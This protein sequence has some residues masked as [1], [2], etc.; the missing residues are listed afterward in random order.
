MN[1]YRVGMIGIAL[2]ISNSVWAEG[3]DELWA[4]TSTMEMPGMP[5]SMPGQTSNICLKKGNEK[6]PNSVI[7][8]NGDQD[9]Q[10]SDVKVSGNKTT[11]KMKCSGKRPMEGKGE[12]TRS[13]GSYSGKTVFHMKRRDMTMVY[14]GKRIG[15]CRAQ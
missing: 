5:M 12:M 3:S 11:W 13:D 9:C 2:L 14:E 6:D 15:K 4:V 10:M 1:K 8:K 7:P